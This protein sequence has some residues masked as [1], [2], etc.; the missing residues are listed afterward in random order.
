M[1]SGKFRTEALNS[2]AMLEQAKVTAIE[3]LGQNVP[4][5]RVLFYETDLNEI[6]NGIKRLNE[7]ASKCWLA[8][9]ITLYTVVYDHKVYEQS[10]LTWE[11]YLRESRNRL[12]IDSHEVCEQLSSARFFIRYHKKLKEAG[13]NPVGSGRKLARAECALEL[14]GDIDE[15]INHIVND[16]V[17]DFQAW[18]TS[19]K[20][21]K[22]L[23]P[24]PKK[25]AKSH[26]IKN[27]DYTDGVLKIDGVNALSVNNEIDSVDKAKLETYIKKIAESLKNGYEPAIVPCYDENEA[28]T[29]IRLR[30]KNR[31]GK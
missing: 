21:V 31:Q 12:S 3:L 26:Q 19:F 18:Y 16:S 7:Y 2:E 25:L 6:E 20:P 4:N 13:W 11:E 9:A 1:A 27:V 28:K 15:T 23:P 8:S 29:M 10:G 5:A 17:R 24:N 22:E 14:T 30:D